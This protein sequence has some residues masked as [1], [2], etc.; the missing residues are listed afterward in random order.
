MT[1]DIG[2]VNFDLSCLLSPQRYLRKHLRKYLMK[3][4]KTYFVLRSDS[5]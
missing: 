3:T 5:D 1:F 2:D 4:V